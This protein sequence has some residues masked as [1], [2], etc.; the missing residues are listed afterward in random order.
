MELSRT[1]PSE[2]YIA[3]L[4]KYQELH[5]GGKLFNGR[6]LKNF[7]HIID[8]LIKENDCKINTTKKNQY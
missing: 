6:S 5:E 7:I 3:C 8:R 2:E 1:N 4:K